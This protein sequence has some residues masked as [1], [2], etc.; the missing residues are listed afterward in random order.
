MTTKHHT[1]EG[2]ERLLIQLRLTNRPY[3]SLNMYKM[4]NICLLEEINYELLCA[5]CIPFTIDE[6][7][8]IL[9][10]LSHQHH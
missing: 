8:D 2:Y 9:D 4:S 3:G 10:A 7:E 6:I 1:R 5:A